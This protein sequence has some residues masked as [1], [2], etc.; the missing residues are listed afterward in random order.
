MGISSLVGQSGSLKEDADS[1]S[2]RRWS[3]SR[4]ALVGTGWFFGCH[5]DEKE[6]HEDG[7]PQEQLAFDV[8][9]RL[10]ELFGRGWSE[11][12]FKFW[13]LVLVFQVGPRLPLEARR[14]NDVTCYAGAFSQ[15]IIAPCADDFRT[16]WG[17]GD[18]AA[19]RVIFLDHKS[20]Q[21]LSIVTGEL[22]S[23]RMISPASKTKSP[24]SVE[25]SK[26]AGTF[27]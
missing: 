14:A 9:E 8:V 5:D 4:W 3:L 27:G 15:N 17:I 12:L 10:P 1:D 6:D 11:L 20:A 7:E 21:N 19:P 2:E 26:N 23:G 22:P 18:M 13:G 25:M 24:C 16:R